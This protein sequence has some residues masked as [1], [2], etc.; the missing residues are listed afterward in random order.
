MTRDTID[1]YF[2]WQLIKWGLIRDFLPKKNLDKS[3]Q[4]IWVKMMFI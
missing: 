1:E 2:V 4:K 3:P